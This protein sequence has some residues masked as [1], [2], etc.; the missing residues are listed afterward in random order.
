MNILALDLGTKTGFA[1]SDGRRGTLQLATP[2]MVKAARACRMDRRCDARIYVLFHWLKTAARDVDWI[3]F[4]DVQFASTTMQAHLW[5]SLRAAVW[6]FSAEYQKKT[7]CCPT[8]TLK[9]FATGH[10]GATKEMMAKA[11]TLKCPEFTLCAADKVKDSTG[12]I[13]DDNAIDALH[14]LNWAKHILQNHEPK[15]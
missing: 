9:L 6:I 4:E 13:L 11:L 5:A 8:G 15:N 7:E 1:F 2:A 10:G 3:A 12:K 14:L